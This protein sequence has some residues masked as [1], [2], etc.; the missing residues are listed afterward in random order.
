MF[1]QPEKALKQRWGAYTRK[2]SEWWVLRQ[3]KFD[4]NHCYRNWPQIKCV[5]V[6]P[7]FA[8]WFA[9]SNPIHMVRSLYLGCKW[10]VCLSLLCPWCRCLRA[11]LLPFGRLQSGKTSERQEAAYAL[12]ESLLILC[13]SHILFGWA[14]DWGKPTRNIFVKLK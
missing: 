8:E 6:I 7:T 1:Q 13:K 14:P 2:P 3:S 4:I 9:S 5:W 10:P 11:S 12:W